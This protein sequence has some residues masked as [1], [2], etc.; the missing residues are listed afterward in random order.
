MTNRIKDIRESKGM[1]RRKLAEQTG[2][3]YTRITDYENGY[4]KT[5]NITVGKLH[6][7]AD[8]LECKIDDLIA[9]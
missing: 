3:S 7:I 6:S 8:A 4:Y 2:I 5:E 9:E 1:T